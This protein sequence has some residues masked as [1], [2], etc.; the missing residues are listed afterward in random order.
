MERRWLVVLLPIVASILLGVSPP[1]EADLIRGVGKIIGGVLQLPLSTL[2]GTFN[3]PP[4]IGTIAGAVT[5]LV[6]GV[7]L[8]THGTLELL[9]SGVSI[10]KTVA[11]FVLPFL[12]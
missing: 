1:A 8:V 2:A 11:P 3:G 12:L 9:A 6:S 7:G 4:I 5:G 10:A